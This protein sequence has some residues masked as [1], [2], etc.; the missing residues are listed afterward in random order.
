M[1]G[2][3]KAFLVLLASL[4]LIVSI[5]VAVTAQETQTTSDVLQTVFDLIDA[6]LYADPVDQSSLKSDFE[7][8]VVIGVLSPEEALAMLDLV[9]WQTL[10]EIEDLANVSAAIQTVLDDLVLGVLTDDPLVDLTR[11]L[12]ELATPEGT[13]TAIGKAGAPQ[14]ILD[15]VSSLA[16]SGI[17]PGVLVQITKE[18][19]RDGLSTEEIMAQLDALAAAVAEESEDVSWGQLVHDVTGEGE[20]RDQERNENIDGNEEPEQEE[21]EHGDG[22]D[23]KDD[24]PGNSG[25]DEE[26]QG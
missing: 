8:A 21:N 9:Q 17:P 26:G 20:Y 2:L 23:T 12:N 18:A 10:V 14:E 7:N 24:N 25:A 15:Q 3:P 16:A 22:N 19:L 4:G 6:N 5:T 11:L 1:A 13:L